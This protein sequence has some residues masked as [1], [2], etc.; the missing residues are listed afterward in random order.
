MAEQTFKIEIHQACIR[1]VESRIAIIKQALVEAQNAAN[2][3]TKSTAGDKHETSRAMAQLETEKLT[4]QLTE[5]LKTLEVLQ[6]V[7]TEKAY[8]RIEHGSLI[9]TNKGYFYLSV[10]LGKVELQKDIAFVISPL[11]PIGKLLLNKKEKETF[12]FNNSNYKILSIY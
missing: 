1:L 8:E 9:L 12:S 6:R 3:E 7:D 4:G 11:S 5:I 10:G 2:N